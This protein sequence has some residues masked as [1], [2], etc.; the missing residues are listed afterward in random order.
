MWMLSFPLLGMFLKNC[1]LSI[2]YNSVVFVGDGSTSSA[3]DYGGYEDII[4]SERSVEKEDS[5]QFELAGKMFVDSKAETYA[6]KK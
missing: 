5:S 6:E 4:V 3:M 2:A 1:S